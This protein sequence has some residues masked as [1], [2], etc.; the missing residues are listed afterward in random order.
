MEFD[1]KSQAI[2]GIRPT[3]IKLLEGHTLVL[4]MGNRLSL[5]AIALLP[6]ISRISVGNFTT[7]SE[8]ANAC[9][10]KKP[11]LL[12]ATEDLEQGYGI[13]LIKA[14]KD[15]SPDTRCLL[16]LERE[17]Q[18]VVREAINANCDAV[19]FQSSIGM[20]SSGDYV[21]ALAAIAEGN[22]YIPSEVRNAAGFDPRPLP[23]LSVK[24]LEVLRVLCT[25]LSNKEMAE[26]LVLSTETIKTHVSSL[27]Q[28]F[29]VKD[30]T[31]VVITAIRAGL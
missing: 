30:R 18:A 23:D 25:G 20:G 27:I 7:Q 13:N 5:A 14:V 22:V 1:P 21:Q 4:A 9:H 16:F 3:H 11:S 2:Q 12:M 28:K 29:G 31:A 24:E 26:A 8:A 17:T 6:E 19:C 10:L 15:A